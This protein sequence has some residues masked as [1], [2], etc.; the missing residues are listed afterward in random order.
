[1]DDIT[2]GSTDEQWNTVDHAFRLLGHQVAHGFAM[3]NLDYPGSGT[4]PSTHALQAG[5]Q[6]WTIFVLEF[7]PS[8]AVLGNDAGAHSSTQPARSRVATPLR[9]P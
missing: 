5:G 1:M 7:G 9:C 2:N 3:G 8:D 4:P 6:P